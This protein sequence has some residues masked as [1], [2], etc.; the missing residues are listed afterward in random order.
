MS[1]IEFLNSCA[2]SYC[3]QASAMIDQADSLEQMADTYFA[4]ATELHGDD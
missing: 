4:R 3:N 2:E 1:E